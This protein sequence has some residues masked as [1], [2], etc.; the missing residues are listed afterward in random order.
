[1]W[2][3]GLLDAALADAGRC[4]VT[5]Q[6]AVAPSPGH[7]PAWAA[8]QLGKHARG[9]PV[10]GG[11]ARPGRAGFVPPCAAGPQST[12]WQEPGGLVRRLDAGAP[13]VHRPCHRTGRSAP[14]S[15]CYLL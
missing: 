15:R 7:K 4:Q 11:C 10:A 6:Q 5:L 12:P 3:S 13:G 9:R 1:M 14:P 2:T 8:V